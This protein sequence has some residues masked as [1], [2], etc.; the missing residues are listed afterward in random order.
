MY[1]DCHQKP[2]KSLGKGFMWPKMWK[3][4]FLD[5]YAAVCRKVYVLDFVSFRYGQVIPVCACW[6]TLY[7]CLCVY[8]CKENL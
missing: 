2:L 4:K 1:T 7:L 6:V 5:F 8:K 3:R